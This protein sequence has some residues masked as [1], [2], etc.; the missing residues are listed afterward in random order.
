MPPSESSQRVAIVGGGP[1]G[2]R[3]AVLLAQSHDVTVYD[4][5]APG[6]E[7]LSL[8]MVRDSEGADVSGPD[9][10]TDLLEEAMGRGVTIEFDEVTALQEEEGG[11]RLLSDG[12]ELVASHVVMATGGAHGAAPV[13]GAD[14]LIGRGV[15]YCAGCDGPMYAGRA[16]AVVGDGP[17]AASDAR[18]LAAFAKVVHLIDSR[19]APATR[20]VPGVEVHQ[21]TS[22]V[23]LVLDR[24]QRVVGLEV[25]GGSGR[26]TVP[27]DGLFVSAPTKP[28]SALL[29]DFATLEPDGGVVVDECL[30][31]GRPG[32]FAIGDVRSGHA[33]GVT[34]ALRDAAV[35]AAALTSRAA[36]R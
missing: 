1:A 36:P 14:Q 26:R 25:D 35:V 8:G 9:L 12:G 34:G 18:T 23:A 16:V 6:G 5:F 33:D 30:N 4:Q 3:L 15:S 13:E 28:R 21:G 7:L 24:E 31:A 22:A 32:L 19:T 2:L 10:A 20:T 29:S 27:V 17:Y 11:W